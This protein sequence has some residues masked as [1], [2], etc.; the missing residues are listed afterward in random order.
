MRLKLL[1]LLAAVMAAPGCVMGKNAADWRV[2]HRPEGAMVT[3]RSG[4]TKLVAELI[5]VRNDAVVLKDRNGRMLLAPYA[6]IDRL[7]A[8]NLGR[9]FAMGS[10]MPP[11]TVARENLRMVSHFPQGMTPAIRDRMLALSK[12]S[13]IEVLK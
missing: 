10:R 2:A 4:S 11:S 7:D 13:E 1:A 12:Q 9:G 6:I 3:L 8:I 5:E